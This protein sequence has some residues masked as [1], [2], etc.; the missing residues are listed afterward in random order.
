MAAT[1]ASQHSPRYRDR[2]P[3]RQA[4]DRVVS[5]PLEHHIA[6][7]TKAVTLLANSLSKQIISTKDLQIALLAAGCIFFGVGFF[8][9]YKSGK[10]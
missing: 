1:Y 8:I 3:S 2:M 7:L 6:D 5:E 9:G 4:G 10:K